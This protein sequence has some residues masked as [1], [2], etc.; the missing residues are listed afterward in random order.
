VLLAWAAAQVLAFAT[1]LKRYAVGAKLGWPAILHPVWSPPGGVV[2][3][4]VLFT[5]VCAASALILWRATTRDKPVA[6]AS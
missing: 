3:V 5:L 2:L 4:V 1:A 6:A